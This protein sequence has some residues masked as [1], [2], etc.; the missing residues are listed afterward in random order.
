M[1]FKSSTV[2]DIGQMMNNCYIVI[3]RLLF[4]F[5]NHICHF[6]SLNHSVVQLVKEH[7]I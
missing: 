5:V 6:K 7:S 3:S 2:Y 4:F 1:G